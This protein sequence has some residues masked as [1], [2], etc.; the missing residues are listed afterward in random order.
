[1]K[2]VAEIDRVCDCQLGIVDVINPVVVHVFVK[3][4]RERLR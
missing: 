3:L 1:M 4:P 2:A